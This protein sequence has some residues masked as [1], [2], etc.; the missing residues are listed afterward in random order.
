[1]NEDLLKKLSKIKMVVSDVDGIL[2]DGT[3]VVSK[4]SEYK[5]F[6]VEDALGTSLL[7]LA[8]IPISFISARDSEATT[9]RLKE[10]KIEHIFQGYVNKLAAL[11]KII[12]IYSIECKDILYIGDGFVDMPVMEKVGF[13][14]SVPNAHSEVKE[15]ADFVTKKSG[16]QG[17]LVEI[18][19]YLLKSKG[20]YDDVFNKMRKHIYEA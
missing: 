1:M 13:S 16:G 14:I 5:T 10:L 12:S 3:I 4:N 19:Q 18:V 17:V 2:T 15:L 7:K 9:A 8:N 6:H 11:D 20:I